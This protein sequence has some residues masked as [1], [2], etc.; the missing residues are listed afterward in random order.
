[1]ALIYVGIGHRD[2]PEEMLKI[3]ETLGKNL[4]ERGHTLRAGA[5]PKG[6]D[7]AF[8]KGC[9]AVNGLK[10]IYL[11]WPG[12]NMRCNVSKGVKTHPSS[13]AMSIADK[14]D[15]PFSTKAEI[16]DLKLMQARQVH[17][18]MG[19]HMNQPA[20]LIIGYKPDEF[21]VMMAEEKNIPV[22]DLADPASFDKLENFPGI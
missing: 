9:D 12:Y 1:M 14:I 7:A 3:M 21:V 18:V 8:E 6:P 22:L 2:T 4:A 15:P 13:E 16:R 20:D 5:I 19:W 10:E 11:P 17:L